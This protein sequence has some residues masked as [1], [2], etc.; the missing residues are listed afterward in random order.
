MKIE[1]S[2][3]ESLLLALIAGGALVACA[4]LQGCG[5]VSGAVGLVGGMANDVSQMSEHA[6]QHMKQSQAPNYGRGH[7]DDYS[8]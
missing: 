5:T 6:R 3:G 2:F 7:Y 8:R 1:S 4:L